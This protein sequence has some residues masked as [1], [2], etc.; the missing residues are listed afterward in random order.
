MPSAAR[1]PAG[2]D[3]PDVTPDP[4]DPSAHAAEDYCYLTTTGRNTGQPHTIEIWFA[5]DAGVVYLMAGGRDTSDWVRNLVA[6]PE[7]R[8]QIG[9]HDWSARARVVEAGAEEDTR[10]RP[11]LRTKY[12]S[13]SDDLVSWARTALPVA[14]EVTGPASAG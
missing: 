10:V 3:D 11:L 14:L 9:D 13:S 7:V 12:A 1:L 5:V 2:C 8:L 4:P 6:H